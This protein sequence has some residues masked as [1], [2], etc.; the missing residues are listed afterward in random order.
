M[1]IEKKKK[2]EKHTSNAILL[3]PRVRLRQ[4]TPEPK[5]RFSFRSITDSRVV[6]KVDE[7]LLYSILR[8]SSIGLKWISEKFE[9]R[10]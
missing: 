9:V 1:Q 7:F 2:K 6:D 8:R 4:S 5:K 3:N 10:F